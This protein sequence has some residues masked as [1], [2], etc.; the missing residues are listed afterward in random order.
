MDTTKNLSSITN[1][2]TRNVNLMALTRVAEVTLPSKTVNLLPSVN[3]ID[4]GARISTAEMFANT[5]PAI[6]LINVMPS[7]NVTSMMAEIIPNLMPAI[8][9][10]NI[11]NETLNN[12]SVVYQAALDSF[13]NNL[14][15]TTL[16]TVANIIRSHWLEVLASLNFNS[17][18]LKYYFC[19]RAVEALQAS[20]IDK[21]DWFVK[22]ICKLSTQYQP[23]VAE[24]LWEGRWRQANDP[25]AYVCKVAKNKSK[26][27][28]LE[29][30]AL[31][32]YRLG[33]LISLDELTTDNTSPIK[34]ISEPHNPF[35]SIE[36]LIDLE[37]ACKQSKLPQEAMQLLI[38]R[39]YGYTRRD[40]E[41]YLGWSQEKVE[42]VWRM[43]NRYKPELIQSFS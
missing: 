9:K 1:S 4:F 21:L 43:I 14:R 17:K 22:D 42:R 29:E 7:I 41:K 15:S 25:I 37:R 3:V 26:R 10:V 8:S 40:A 36:L 19:E 31:W 28:Q 33:A 27:H 12:A 35:V 20:D 5:I 18:L 38:A 23:F 2:F 13:V 34:L 24:A 11:I 6:R 32:N 16:T 39:S 30:K